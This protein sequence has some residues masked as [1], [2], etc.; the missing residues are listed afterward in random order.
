MEEI[1]LGPVHLVMIQL[2]N[3]ELRGEVEEEILM[4]SERNIIRVFDLLAVRREPDGTFTTLE[5]TELSDEE[6]EDLGAIIG[7]LLGLG[8]EGELGEEEGARIGAE[9]FAKHSFGLSRAQLRSMA[10]E[11]PVGKTLLIVLF[12]HKWALKLKQATQK[13]NGFILAEGIIRPEALVEIG[14]AAAG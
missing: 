9:R 3:E 14:P 2:D 7:D 1:K 13:A 4:A 8:A 5:A 11:I 10:D 6:H 12:E